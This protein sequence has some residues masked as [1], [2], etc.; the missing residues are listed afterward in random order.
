MTSPPPA[1]SAPRR[2]GGSGA[3]PA[4][5]AGPATDRPGDPP[6]PPHRARLRAAALHRAR[7]RRQRCLDTRA[8]EPPEG[9]QPRRRHGHRAVRPRRRAGRSSTLLGQGGQSPVELESADQ[10]AAQRRRQARRP[11]RGLRRPR[12]AARPPSATCCSRST[13][14]P[15]ALGKIA[16]RDPHRARP[17]ATRPRRRST[18]SPRRCSSSSSSDVIYDARVIPFIQEALDERE[19]GGQDI[20]GLAVPARTSSG[21]SPTTVAERLGAAAGGGDGGAADE[22]VAPGLHGH[23]L[24]S[25][26]V[27]DTDA[28]AGRDRQPHPGGVGHRVHRHVRQPGR[29]RGAQRQRR[30]SAIR[31]GGTKTI[32]ARARVDADHGRAR[33]PRRPSRSRRRRR[34][35]RRSRSRS[36]SARC[37]A[38]RRSTTTARAT[39]RSSRDRRSP[40]LSSLGV[41]ELSSTTGIV[42]LAAAGAGARRARLG[43]RPDVQLRR[44]RAAQIGGAR[45]AR[46]SATSSA[47]PPSSTRRSAR[48]ATTSRSCTRRS[49]TASRR[50]RTRLDHAIAY[51]G[52]V[53]FDAYNEM[54][55]RQSTSIALLDSDA[56]GHRHLLD[57]PPRPGARL[58][59]AGA[60]RAGR[61]RARARGGGGRAAPR[62]SRRA[63]PAAW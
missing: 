14:A 48:C 32:T 37:P 62:S 34:S 51:R 46:R 28:P 20:A 3:R 30:R 59:Q 54:S 27:G 55:G 2:P 58:R 18:R 60:R 13:C 24:V 26:A 15:P 7:D 38:R 40:G 61:A 11:G 16:G 4:V 23:G 42:A 25:T 44:L 9:L 6:A 22:D 39:R 12:R 8:R 56:L 41:D 1:R 57:P 5:A 47:T 36:P 10:P 21:S 49:T 45:R 53:R 35:A 50:P 29:E 52:L 19:I 17:R 31:G 63:G 43:D 33:T